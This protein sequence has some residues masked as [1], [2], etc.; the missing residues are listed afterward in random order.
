MQ[1]VDD[2]RAGLGGVAASHALD[3]SSSLLLA[4]DPRLGSLA[5]A[6]FSKCLHFM[7]A[8]N[9]LGFFF[10]PKISCS[11]TLSFNPCVSI[12]LVLLMFGWW[13]TC[14]FVC[15]FLLVLLGFYLFV[16]LP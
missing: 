10:H 2:Y 3:P 9:G 14:L 1:N 12:V 15:L 11:V 7:W 6:S 4:G 13:L 5:H 16:S 8:P